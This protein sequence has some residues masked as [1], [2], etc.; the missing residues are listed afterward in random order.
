MKE[1]RV[2]YFSDPLNDDFANNNIKTCNIAAGFCYVHKSILWKISSFFI[3]YIIALPLVWLMA[4]ILLGLKFKNRKVL[5][6]L[7]GQGFFLYGNHT[8]A[9]D[10]YIPPLAAFPKRSYI[11][12]NPDA[13]S[14]P[15]IK[16]LVMMLGALPIPSKLSGFK[17]FMDATYTRCAE[18]AC[19]AIYPEAHIWP[20]YTGIRPFSDSS[21]RYPVTA[22]APVVAMV[23]TYR[24]R[25]GLFCFLKRPGMTVTFSE[26][27]YPD[28]ELT[29]R[30]AQAKLREQAFDFMD[31][32]SRNTQQVEYI[33]YEYKQKNDNSYVTFL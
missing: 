5:R 7:K 9:L 6:K 14:I 18:N 30:Q 23:T 28:K 25:R 29:A 3:Y 22:D 27:F 33:R 19:I 4:K 21:F 10:A 16:N 2:V 1:N 32:T 17:Q 11:L 13:V 15:G 24:K 26:V 12:A 8:Q 31:N 20:Y